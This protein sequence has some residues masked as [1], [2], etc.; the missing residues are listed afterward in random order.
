MVGALRKALAAFPDTRTGKNTRYEVLD[1]AAGAFS[2]FF[3]QCSSFLEYQRLLE[4]RYGL[5]NAR[6][7]FRMQAIPSDTHIRDLLDAVSPTHLTTVFEH[8]IET[9]AK[10]D[11]LKGFRVTLGEQE[12][13]LLIALDGTWYSSSE[14]V[15]CEQC[16][17]KVKEGKTIYSHGMVNPAIV[18]PGNSHIFCL[19]PEFI[20]P[21]D[22]DKKQDSEH[23][24]S[25]RWIDTH[26]AFYRQFGGVTFVGDDLYCHE[27]M[28]REMLGA[29]CNFILVCKPDSHKTL[30]EWA[31]GIRKRL[32]TETR[33]GNKRYRY[34]YEY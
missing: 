23:K 31:K 26:A 27:P 13:D 33:D 19:P 17:T 20:T 3:T 21:Q 12:K 34:I 6:T 2:V 28:C 15:Y 14:K 29:E 10:Q 16:S 4:S 8:C 18:H 22:G 7:L 25:K 30:Y 32:K 24:A 11:I 9:L 1:A 5:S